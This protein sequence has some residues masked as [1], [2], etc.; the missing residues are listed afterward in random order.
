MHD[1]TQQ[2]Q[3]AQ[4]EICDPIKEKKEK[5]ESKYFSSTFCYSL[6]LFHVYVSLYFVNLRKL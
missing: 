1:I 2:N 3:A 5:S 4:N 6:M